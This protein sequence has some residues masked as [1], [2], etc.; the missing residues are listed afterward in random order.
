MVDRADD[1]DA[2]HPP[3]VSVNVSEQ[4]LAILARIA[5]LRIEQERLPALAR[6]LSMTLHM[7]SDLDAVL[8]EPV[9]PVIRPFD[10]AWTP[11]EGTGR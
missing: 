9:V 11:E 3:T 4:E 6:D 8:Q 2:Q 7:A 10:P 1:T 5:G